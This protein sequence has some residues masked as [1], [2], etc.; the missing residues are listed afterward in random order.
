MMTHWRRTVAALLIGLGIAQ[1]SIVVLRSAALADD[2]DESDEDDDEDLGDWILRLFR[3]FDDPAP[4][5]PRQGGKGDGG[6]G[7]GGHG[8]GSAGGGGGPRGGG[9]DDD[10]GGGDDGGEGGE[11]GGGDDD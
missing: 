5:P 6:G 8:S 4:T 11:G 10:G 9:G 2:A 7:E 1:P 3:G